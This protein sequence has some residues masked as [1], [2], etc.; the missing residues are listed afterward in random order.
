[1][2]SALELHNARH[3][4]GHTARIIMA[5]AANP[6]HPRKTEY[7]RQLRIYRGAWAAIDADDQA[8]VVTSLVADESCA[9]LTTETVALAVAALSWDG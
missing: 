8:D 6:E 9:D 4:V 2:L 3:V 5:L 1:M 7:A